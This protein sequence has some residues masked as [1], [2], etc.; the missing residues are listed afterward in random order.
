M[1]DNDEKEKNR[2]DEFLKGAKNHP[3]L[4][5]IIILGIIIIGLGNVSDACLKLERLIPTSQ[6]SPTPTNSPKANPTPTLATATVTI[7]RST[8][9]PVVTPTV[10][11]RATETPTI[12]PTRSPTP[13]VTAT[14]CSNPVSPIFADAWNNSAINGR[15]RCA[16]AIAVTRESVEET[17]ERGHMV[18]RG[19]GVQVYAIYNDG[20]WD[21]FPKSPNDILQDGDPE[22]FCGEHR[23]PPSPRRGFSKIWCN[24]KDVRD[25]IGNATD[26]EEGFCMPSNCDTFQDFEGGT[27]YYSAKY[28]STYI[29]FA[30]KTWQRR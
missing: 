7:A 2:V 27:I 12:A 24:N 18:W 1:R 21:I 14:P 28:N 19:G 3:V 22:Y 26:Y 15:L 6:P 11:P 23:S 13:T 8:S 25:K 29:L 17:F 10:P 30:D 20:T 16:T 4:S 5:L 9:T